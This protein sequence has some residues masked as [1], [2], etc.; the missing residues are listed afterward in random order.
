[1]ASPET[2]F[3]HMMRT[4]LV[5]I[6]IPG[7]LTLTLFGWHAFSGGLDV[8]DWEARQCEVVDVNIEAWAPR[9][10]TEISC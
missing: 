6:L 10:P 3:E 4:A 8:R 9:L 7:G 5:I 1:M 2:F